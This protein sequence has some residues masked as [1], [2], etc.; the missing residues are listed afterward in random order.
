MGSSNCPFTS[1][2]NA[3]KDEN[4]INKLS[5]FIDSIDS[6]LSS[7][8][9]KIK[10]SIEEYAKNAW[11]TGVAALQNLLP[12]ESTV[13]RVG[14]YY[15]IE[16]DEIVEEYIDYY[17]GLQKFAELVMKVSPEDNVNPDAICSKIATVDDKDIS[18]TDSLFCDPRYREDFDV[19]DTVKQYSLFKEVY[20]L[21]NEF[22]IQSENLI[23]S[24]RMAITPWVNN[25]SIK[26]A[27]SVVIMTALFVRSWITF[28]FKL[29]DKLKAIPVD[30]VEAVEDAKDEAVPKHVF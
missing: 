17:K 23:T 29:L 4:D 27:K 22:Y 5:S 19:E 3:I 9:D 11:Q 21:V 8:T 12:Y 26:N 25:G 18:S 2:C 14:N 1:L 10:I 24:A 6:A 16:Y 15:T 20:D 30:A 7:T 13:N 28:T